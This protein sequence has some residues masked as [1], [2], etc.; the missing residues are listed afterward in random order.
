[1]RGRFEFYLLSQMSLCSILDLTWAGSF[2]PPDRALGE[3]HTHPCPAMVAH[4]HSDQLHNRGHG[5]L[6]GLDK[7]VLWQQAPLC[8]CCYITS[9]QMERWSICHRLIPTV[10]FPPEVSGSLSLLP[11]FQLVSRL[12]ALWCTCPC[13]HP[14]TMGHSSSSSWDALY[15]DL[16]TPG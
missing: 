12:L 11:G 1:M 6:F 2:C 7:S 4:W 3:G 15:L 16:S 5:V 13:P 8:P 10:P 9:L 14:S